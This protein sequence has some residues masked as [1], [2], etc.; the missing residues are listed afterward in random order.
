MFDSGRENQ[1]AHGFLV[2]VALAE[3]AE[4]GEP[5]C[6]LYNVEALA[7]EDAVRRVREVTGAAA[8]QVHPI[9]RL[10]N[11]EFIAA[12]LRS[13]GLKATGERAQGPVRGIIPTRSTRAIATEAVGS[14]TGRAV[15]QPA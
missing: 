3:V 7:Q 14:R 4:D 2:S 12:R 8:D 6:Q 13:C 5:T 9:R 11:G 10:S 15:H 1:V